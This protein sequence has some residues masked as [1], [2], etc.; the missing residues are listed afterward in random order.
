MGR[1]IDSEQAQIMMRQVELKPTKSQE[2]VLKSYIQVYN[3]VYDTVLD[4]IRTAKK[5]D[6]NIEIPTDVELSGLIRRMCMKENR[7]ETRR[8]PSK[9]FLEAAHDAI[10]DYER[11]GKI[12]E[13][14]C[15]REYC[16]K[17]GDRYFNIGDVRKYNLSNIKIRGISN[18]IHLSSSVTADSEFG[19]TI[20][21]S[22]GKWYVICTSS[23]L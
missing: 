3:F 5:Y 11:Y 17:N 13:S 18:P 10:F 22:G 14:N 7:V 1:R 12:G 21:Y 16:I 9:L 2:R 6:N 20:E 4:M 8:I 23:W 19:S 15:L